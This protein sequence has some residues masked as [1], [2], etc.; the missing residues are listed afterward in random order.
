MMPPSIF[1]RQGVPI[2]SNQADALCFN[3]KTNLGASCKINDNLNSANDYM[4]KQV[5]HYS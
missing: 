2:P 4:T 1:L 5:Y 3:N